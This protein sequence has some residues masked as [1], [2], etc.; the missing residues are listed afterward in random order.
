MSLREINKAVPCKHT[1]PSVMFCTLVARLHLHS[2]KERKNPKLQQFYLL[3][4]RL[5]LKVI[6][7]EAYIC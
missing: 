7:L 2:G 3:K 5:I 6:R 4:G 1:V